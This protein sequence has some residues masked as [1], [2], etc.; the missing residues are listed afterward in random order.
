MSL[1]NIQL[2]A[3]VLHDLF[4]HSLVDLN[5]GTAK[6]DTINTANTVNISF[7]GTNQ[8]Q[9]AIIVD[10][11][12]TIYLPDEELNFLLGIL[13]ACK[14]SMADVALVNIAKNNTLIYTDIAQ[15]LNAEKILLF[16]VTPA[17]LQL[18]LQFPHY[19][20]QKFNTQVYLSAPS[21][22][23]I[24]EDKAEKTK[25]WNCLKQIFL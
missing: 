16:A 18:P 19:Q 8:K 12:K 14:L 20:I 2:P 4:K 22:Q 3:I 25:L 9:I 17:Q 1:D 7:L 15:Q 6:D 10:N 21:L 13:S 24:E 5:A 11:E 23:L